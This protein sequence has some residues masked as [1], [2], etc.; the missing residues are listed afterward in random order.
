MK[1][2]KALG[3]QAL[4][5]YGWRVP[6]CRFISEAENLPHYTDAPVFVR[7]CPM[8]PRHGFVDSRVCTT[9]AEIRTVWDPADDAV[10]FVREHHCHKAIET[11]AQERYLD[12][13]DEELNV[14]E[15]EPVDFLE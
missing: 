13:L 12:D 15:D 2:Q 6:S 14:V 9:A 7:P 5:Y 10:E 4:S 3:I 8:R 11:L 1:T